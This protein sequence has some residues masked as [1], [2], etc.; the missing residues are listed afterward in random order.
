MEN[1]V[2]P[3]YLNKNILNVIQNQK[4]FEF[5]TPV[6]AAT[7]KSF[8]HNKDVLVRAE[9]GS[10]KTLAFLVPILNTLMGKCQNPKKNAVLSLV[11]TPTKE[12]ACQ[13][14]EELEDFLKCPEIPFKSELLVGGVKKEERYKGSNIIVCTPG[15]LLHELEISHLATSVKHLEVLVLD[16]ADRLFERG[17]QREITSIFSLL[18]KQ[19][20]TGLFSATLEDSVELFKRAGLRNC[21]KIDVARHKNNSVIRTPLTLVNKFIMCSELDKLNK[22][23]SFI[24]L[25]KDEK[26]VVF[27][28][29]CA[30][31]DYFGNAIKQ[32]IDNNNTVYLLHGKL[33]N[34]K[35]ISRN[36]VL[37]QFRNVE[38]GVLVCTDVA[39]R[40]IDIPDVDWVLQYD[41]PSKPENFLHRSGR[42]AR[43][44]RI[45]K[46]LMFL[47]V[48]EDAYVPYLKDSHK[49]TLEEF[50]F[51][52]EDNTWLKKLK[53]L[54]MSDRAMMDR[55]KRA[56]VSFIQAY[57]KHEL[58]LIF[59]KRDINFG[60]LATG[61]ALLEMPGMPE[62]K[63]R[64]IVGFTP[65]SPDVIKKIKYKNQL[66]EKQRLEKL[67]RPAPK[68]TR[69][70]MYNHNSK[71]FSKS[72]LDREE[73]KNKKRQKK[74]RKEQ[75]KRMKFD[76][77]EEEELRRDAAMVKKEKNR[78]ITKEQYDQSISAAEKEIFQGKPTNCSK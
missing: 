11:I 78:K 65:V 20:Q 1:T 60:L 48:Q 18:P 21:N 52:N 59:R 54:A 67:K 73:K 33:V 68:P 38:K 45:G 70:T 4:K 12:L 25:H 2:W 34:R 36:A 44:G 26:I 74:M 32:L 5:M 66:R 75:S 77:D 40:G 27:F 63:N 23:F 76:E 71:K 22:L 50:K 29:T 57:T 24:N 13:I 56:Y 14:H 47:L 6:Q 58:S 55:G 8:C 49:V 3:S 41:P 42:T 39:A 16:E 72:R 61:Y 51:D 9:T 62:T 64:K 35:Q 17:F 69:P 15:R 46:A 28:S 10:G 31:V 30:S 37:K 7:L 19:R 43:N 53:Q